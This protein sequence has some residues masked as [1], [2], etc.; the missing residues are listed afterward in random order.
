MQLSFLVAKAL[1]E[2]DFASYFASLPSA[3][4]EPE[5]IVLR[6]GKFER[7]SRME[8]EERGTVAVAVLVVREVAA[9]AEA[10]AIACEKWIRAY[11]WEPVAEN[12]SC[13]IVGLDTTAPSFKEIDGSGRFVWAFDVLLT[14]VRGI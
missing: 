6:E 4:D 7:V 8:H 12:G 5:P 11:G 14:V 10:D 3:D 2:G 13:R 9:T 1:L